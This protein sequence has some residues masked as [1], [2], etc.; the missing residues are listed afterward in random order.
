MPVVSAITLAS[1]S[2][3]VNGVALRPM[4]QRLP[5][6]ADRAHLRGVHPGFVQQGIRGLREGLAQARIEFAER[7]QVHPRIRL[8]HLQHQRA[9]R[10]GQ[11]R[12]ARPQQPRRRIGAE[13]HQRGIDAVGAGAGNQ[14][15]KKAA[16][17]VSGPFVRHVRGALS[18]KPTGWRCSSRPSAAWPPPARS[19]RGT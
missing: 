6:R 15:K 16:E 12:G 1:P 9:Q 8:R 13:V 7:V 11:R 18:A 14:P 4:P 10:F 2:C 17:F 3:R 5:V 19:P